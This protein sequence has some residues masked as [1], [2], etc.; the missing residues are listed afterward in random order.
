MSVSAT[1]LAPAPSQELDRAQEPGKWSARRTFAFVVLVCSTFWL[2]FA[3]IIAWAMSI[4]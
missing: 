1:T 2:A 4:V 3:A